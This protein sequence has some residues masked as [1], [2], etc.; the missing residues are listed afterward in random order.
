[1]TLKAR[2]KSVSLKHGNIFPTND[3]TNVTIISLRHPAVTCTLHTLPV[4]R[5]RSDVSSVVWLGLLDAESI[6]SFRAA[7]RMGMFAIKSRGPELRVVRIVPPTRIVPEGSA[8]S[9]CSSPTVLS[10]SRPLPIENLLVILVIA[11]TVSLTQA[12]LG[13]ALAL[14]SARSKR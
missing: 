4:R 3:P 13:S 5:R 10:V 1:M 14:P 12:Q 8:D 11:S 9:H 2:I 6:C 7:V